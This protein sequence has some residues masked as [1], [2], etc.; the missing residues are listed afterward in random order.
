[1]HLLS[2]PKTVSLPARPAIFNKNSILN[3]LHSKHKWKRKWQK[4]SEI[5]VHLVSF[6]LQQATLL[7][8][9]ASEWHLQKKSYLH[10]QWQQSVT[11]FSG[12]RNG[13]EYVH[14]PK[15]IQ[16]VHDFTCS[17]LLYSI[18]MI[19]ELTLQGS[20]HSILIAIASFTSPSH[21]TC[22]WGI[23]IIW[24]LLPWRWWQYIPPKH[25]YPPMTWHH[26]PEDHDMNRHDNMYFSGVLKQLLIIYAGT[27]RAQVSCQRCT[28]HTCAQCC[29]HSA[30]STMTRLWFL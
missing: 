21:P 24:A 27:Y 8:F 14:H 1:M 23:C 25:W 13:S 16:L 10:T 18:H 5:T 17:N 2:C 6:E 4:Q 30:H 9:S 29:P 20:V 12:D 15:N 26:D 11:N 28:Q 3:L 7:S 22:H 19:S